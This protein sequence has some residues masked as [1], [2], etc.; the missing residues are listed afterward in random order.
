MNTMAIKSNNAEELNCTICGAMSFMEYSFSDLNLYRCPNCD[1]CFSDLKGNFEEYD[2]EYFNVSHANWFNNP[3]IAL[4]ETYN[5]SITNF[6]PDASVIDI[7]CGR[8]DFLKFL[9]KKNHRLSL[10]GIDLYENSPV[11]GVHFLHADIFS[12]DLN[13]Q[14]DVVVNTAVIEH[15]ADVQKF[16]RRLYEL[17]S[18]NGLV[19]ITTV[20][21]R[22]IIYGISRLLHR[23]GCT[24]PLER[25]YNRH[26]LNHFN[27]SSL[28]HLLHINELSVKKI[29]FHNF[30][31][32]AVDS[33]VQSPIFNA[34]FRSG[35]WGIF[36][37]SR[38]MRSTYFQTVVCHKK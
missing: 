38:L 7:G 35:V 8:G 18:P 10:T 24:M 14:F 29:L 13:R 30:P 23:F 4:F 22:G 21:D 34:I 20:N 2:S 32:S 5:K 1:H 9:R 3:N 33:P 25:L 6:K 15:V 28:S 19:I 17:C 11:E 26:H 27:V 31:L 36:M 12:A 37:L 16:T